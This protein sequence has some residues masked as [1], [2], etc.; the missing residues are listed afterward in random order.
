MTAGNLFRKKEKSY[1]KR[2]VGGKGFAVLPR[3]SAAQQ[4]ER[5][6]S[7]SRVISAQVHRLPK[8]QML[9]G[10]ALRVFSGLASGS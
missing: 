4:S 5:L 6:R 10:E 9:L 3:A 1:V 8:S 7:K 2:A